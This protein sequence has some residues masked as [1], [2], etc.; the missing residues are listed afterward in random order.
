MLV[1]Y[2]AG[3]THWYLNTIQLNDPKYK[4]IMEVTV[5]SSFAR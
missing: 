1:I 3:F 5:F 4:F 2:E